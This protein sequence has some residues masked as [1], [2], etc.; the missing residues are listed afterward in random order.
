MVQITARREL[1]GLAAAQ[2][3]YTVFELDPD[4]GQVR[5]E[6]FA[7]DGASLYSGTFTP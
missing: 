7:E 4:S 2:N 6:F 5:I 1:L 3:S